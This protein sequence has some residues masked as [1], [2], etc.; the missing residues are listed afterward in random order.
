MT[1]RRGHRDKVMFEFNCSLKI[2]E[3]ARVRVRA[4][5]PGNDAIKDWMDS[6]VLAYGSAE[7]PCMF[8][9]KN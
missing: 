7:S 9:K 3:W 6:E 8:T 4:K 5:K 1:L 2:C